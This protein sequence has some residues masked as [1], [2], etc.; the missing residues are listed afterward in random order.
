MLIVMSGTPGGRVGAGC[1]FQQAGSVGGGVAS[2][3]AWQCRPRRRPYPP[4]CRPWRRWRACRQNGARCKVPPHRRAGGVAQGV[5]VGAA[6]LPLNVQCVHAALGQQ[7]AAV[8]GVG[9]G[10]QASPALG[11]RADR[12]DQRLVRQAANQRQRGGKIDLGQGSRRSSTTSAAGLRRRPRPAGAGTPR[13][14]ANSGTMIRGAAA[15]KVR[16]RRVSI[17]II[18]SGQ[19]FLF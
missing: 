1:G 19:F 13:L 15:S 14:R 5:A 12:H 3:P 16:P 6:G 9:V 18:L 8:G 4:A 10:H 7:C 2:R 17:K 11:F